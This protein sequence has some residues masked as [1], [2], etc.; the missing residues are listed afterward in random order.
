MVVAAMAKHVMIDEVDWKRLGAGSDLLR[1]L[2]FFIPDLKFFPE[3]VVPILETLLM[4]FW[5]T[6]LALVLA[7]PVAFLAARNI[8]PHRWVTFPLGRGIIVVSRSTHEVIFA[9]IYVA[10]LGLGPLPGILALASRSLGFIAKTTAEAIENVNRGP[11]EAMQ[12]AGANSISTFVYGVV[13]QVFP[14]LIGNVIFSLEINLRRASI[15]GVVGAG[16]I[17]FA[18]AETMQTLQYDRAGTIVL[19]LIGLVLAGEL[20]SN[21]VRARFL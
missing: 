8:T 11:I 17:G 4:A 18:F 14:V 9:L 19:A 16:G 2:S 20:L 12:A 1:T 5:G 3:I 7:M 15:L 13:P 6:L 21:R 10:A